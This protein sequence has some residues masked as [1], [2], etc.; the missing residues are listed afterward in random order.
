MADLFDPD[1]ASLVDVDDLAIRAV[2]KVL[3]A[4]HFVWEGA[5]ERYGALV[6]AW[7]DGGYRRAGADAR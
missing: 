6:R 2:A 3:D 5:P 7:V 4:E 1:M